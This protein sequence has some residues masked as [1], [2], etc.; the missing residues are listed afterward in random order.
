MKVWGGL[1]VGDDAITSCIQELRH[2]LGD[3]ARK[4]LYIET[5]HRRGYRLIAPVTVR[6]ALGVFAASPVSRRAREPLAELNRR[7]EL[8]VEGRRQLVLVSGEPGIGKSALVDFFLS[9]CGRSRHQDRPGP[10]L[11]HHGADEPYLPMIDALTRGLASAP[12]G[13]DL[14][15]LLS[16]QAPGSAGHALAVDTRRARVLYRARRGDIR[17]PAGGTHVGH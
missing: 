1:A 6:I 15:R 11:D 4:P 16:H 14:L 9:T 7:F 13:R 12:D 3:K 8:A 5:R 10:C 17:V 2:A